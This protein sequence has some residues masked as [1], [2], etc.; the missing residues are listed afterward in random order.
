MQPAFFLFFESFH[1]FVVSLQLGIYVY[2]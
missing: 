1:S 2:S